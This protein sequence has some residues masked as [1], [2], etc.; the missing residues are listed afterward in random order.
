MGVLVTGL[1]TYNIGVCFANSNAISYADCAV[2]PP[3]SLP[4]VNTAQGIT[5]CGGT[6]E[7][8]KKVLSQFRKD[9]EERLSLLRQ[10]PAPDALPLF[11]TQVHALKSAAAIIGAAELPAQAA[12][13][14]AAGKAADTAA[15]AAILPAFA[16]GLAA[17]AAAIGAAL[18]GG[19]EDSVEDSAAAPPTPGDCAPLL[20]ELAAALEARNAAETDRILEELL[21]MPLDKKTKEAVEQIANHIL[22]TE[23]GKALETVRGLCGKDPAQ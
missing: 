14:E 2:T 18:E 23:Y 13:L 7:L 11:V 3:P 5:L 17:L 6:P 15:I 4:G 9:A 21:Q 8:Y 12:A 20:R 16:E 10:T 19:A 22:M 1:L